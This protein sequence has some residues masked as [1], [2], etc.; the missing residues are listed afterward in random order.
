[1]IEEKNLAAEINEKLLLAHLSIV[2]A[3]KLVEEHGS[4]RELQAFRAG[5]AS[6]A[7]HLFGLLLRPLWQTH[8]EL[9]PEGLDMSPPSKKK[10][11]R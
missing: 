8:P 2:D 7:G 4:E 3:L 1:M 10:G 11:K 9:A 6:V 5:A